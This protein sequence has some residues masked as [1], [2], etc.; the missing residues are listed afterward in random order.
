MGAPAPL[1]AEQLKPLLAAYLL[2]LRELMHHMPIRAIHGLPPE[3]A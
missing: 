2:I 1:G 3:S